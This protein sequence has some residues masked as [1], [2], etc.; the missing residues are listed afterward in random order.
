MRLML[1]HGWA[2]SAPYFDPL[3]S[4]LDPDLVY[5][6]SLD[7]PGHGTSG[8]PRA[9]YTLDLVADAVIAVADAA[10]ADTFVL[11][12]FSMSAKF[13]QY[14]A[15][16]HP[17]RTLGQLLVA[18]CPTGR[19]PLPAEM[20][21]DWYSRAGDAARLIDVALSCTTRPIP[22]DVLEA[23]RQR[24][25]TRDPDRPGGDA[26]ALLRKRLRRAG[27]GLGGAHPRRRRAGRL[28]LPTRSPA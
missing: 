13:A 25:S 2:G 26:R 19:I 15:M 22:G 28:D 9:P 6:V 1:M 12:G 14:V 24:C 3:I 4:H 27:G 7:L 20:V 11:L 17:D 5:C 21:D 10:R 8:E 16:R 23:F 18:G